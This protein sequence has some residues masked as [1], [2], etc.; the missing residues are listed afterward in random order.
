MNDTCNECFYLYQDTEIVHNS[1]TAD[2]I[3]Y[4][5]YRCGKSIK[6][7]HPRRTIELTGPDYD[8]IKK[9]EETTDNIYNINSINIDRPS[10]CEGFQNE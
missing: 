5:I 8:I 7:L 10:W 6:N 4:I 1:E 3:I 9:I 2:D